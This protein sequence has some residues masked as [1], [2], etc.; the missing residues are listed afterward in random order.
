MIIESGTIIALGLLFTF[1]KLDWRKRMWMLSNPVKMDIGIFVSLV[2][3][4]MGTFS[5]I[6]AATTGAMICSAMLS[7][8]RWT[9]GHVK[10][11]LYFPGLFDV[12]QKL[13]ESMK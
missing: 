10:N 1:L 12:S 3:I 5:G 11:N 2:L 13:L 6:M 7:V 8:G 4:H 9:F